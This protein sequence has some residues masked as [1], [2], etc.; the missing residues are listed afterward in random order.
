MKSVTMFVMTGCPY[1][2]QA[3]RALAELREEQPE[4]QAVEVQEVN[5][6]KN[7]AL[8]DQYDYYYVP[9][10]FLGTEKLYEAHP[11]ESYSECKEQVER[12]LKEA[13]KN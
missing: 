10:M 2:R 1:C 4:L 6:N 5:E 13:C 9:S 12:V 3:K 8:A 11:G 7:P